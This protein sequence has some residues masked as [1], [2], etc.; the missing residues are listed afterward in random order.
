[1]FSS[2][3]N[4]SQTFPTQSN[5]QQRNGTSFSFNL[6]IMENGDQPWDFSGGNDAEAGK[7]INTTMKRSIKI[8][9]EVA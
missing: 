2:F 6:H 7:E 8:P 3:L 9:E 1:M 5:I 4:C